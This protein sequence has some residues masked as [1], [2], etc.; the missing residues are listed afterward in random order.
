MGS[1]KLLRRLQANLQRLRLADTNSK[2]S[3][4]TYYIS[5]R[6]QDR[7][8]EIYET[9]ALIKKEKANVTAS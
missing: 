2:Q 5:G 9:M 8:Q 6:Q 3:D 4:N 1:R 7:Q